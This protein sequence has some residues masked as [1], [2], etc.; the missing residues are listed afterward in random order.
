MKSLNDD[1]RSE[2]HQIKDRRF[3]E[4][5]TEEPVHEFH[6]IPK[7]IGRAFRDRLMKK[8]VMFV[9]IPLQAEC[10]LPLLAGADII[11]ISSY[12]ASISRFEVFEK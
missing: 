10:I 4:E 1:A 7:F 5:L 3:T 2:K 11:E 6:C 12:A 8:P 9:F